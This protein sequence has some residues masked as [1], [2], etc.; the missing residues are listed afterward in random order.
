MRN[1]L[2]SIYEIYG[3]ATLSKFLVN[4][5]ADSGPSR[6]TTC[7]GFERGGGQ[8]SGDTVFSP[9]GPRGQH[10]ACTDQAGVGT[11]KADKEAS[12]LLVAAAER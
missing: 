6:V 1:Y 10:G 11:D 2:Q 5:P 4:R 7:G 12:S 8:P 9:L 3:E